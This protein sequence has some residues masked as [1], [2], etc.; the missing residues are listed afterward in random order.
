V[1]GEVVSYLELATLASSPAWARSETRSVLGAWHVWQETIE[2]AELLVSELVTNAVK[3]ANPDHWPEDSDPD[4]N[5][6]ISLILRYLA[7]RLVIE[8]ADPNPAPPVIA[9]TGDDAEGGR[10][11]MLVQELSKDWNFY[12]PPSGGKVVYCVLTA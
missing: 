5:K 10:G 12:F 2:T 4:G 11:L 3:F 7:D 8:V 6:N 9:D 1:P